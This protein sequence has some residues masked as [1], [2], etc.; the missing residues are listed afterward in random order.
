MTEKVYA[1]LFYTHIKVPVKPLNAVIRKR[2][3]S[4]TLTNICRSHG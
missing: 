4:S 3:I 2:T 1:A